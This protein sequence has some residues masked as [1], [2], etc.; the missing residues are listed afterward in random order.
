MGMEN[1]D[2]VVV[3]GGSAGCVLANRLSEKPSNRVLLLEAGGS[4]N[5]YLVKLSFGFAFMLNNPRYDWRFECGPE[6][7]TGGRTLPYPRGKILGGSSSINA[8]LYVRGFKRD[9]DAWADDGLTGW[10]WD[11]VEPYLLAMESFD[12]PSPWNRGRDGPVKLSMTPSRH[13]LTDRIVEAVRQSSLGF[14]DDY[15]G[16]APSGIGY[17]QYFYHNGRRCG[18]AAAHLR[19]AMKRR[20]LR[21]ETGA[22]ARS[23][24]F[25]C[26]RATG[27]TYEKDGTMI[28]VQAG[29]T[30][31]AAGAVGSPQLMEISGL[32]S[33]VRLSRLGIDVVADLPAVG[34][35]MQDHYLVFIV[36][37][38]KGLKG[39]GAE[40]NGWRAF[41]NGVRYLLFNDGFMKSLPTQINGHK[42]IEIDGE[43]TGL[44]FMGM[45][46]S[47]IWDEKRKKIL[48]NSD[49]AMMLGANVCRPHSRG[50]IHI[51]SADP[52]QKPKI[53]TNF[54]SDQRDVDA[55]VEGLKLCREVIAQPAL[56]SNLDEEAK[57][58][59]DVQSDEELE[60]YARLAGASAY[61][62]VGTCRMGLDPISSVVDARLRVHGIDGL[63]IVDASVMPRIV[64]A[65]THAPT[66]M[67]AEKASDFIK[68]DAK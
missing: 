68:E 3:G 18:S 55:I 43:T 31:L 41:A 2:Y 7:N 36:Q 14:T 62:P 56:A 25:D 15:N 48:R 51:E 35:H 9:Y 30:I 47:F 34:D 54:M 8:M 38:L 53:V 17:S 6:E 26:K 23:I 13:P 50:H 64:S 44:Q 32:G 39:L 65:N 12:G 40:L 19:P 42:D 45:P 22:V 29:E 52:D 11:D 37:D 66:V 28:T 21:V 60:S 27:V 46:M 59:K 49:P 61:H 57:P 5:S 24:T 10:E 33:A 63:R 20:N 16:P 67:I 58:G 1:Y 4:D